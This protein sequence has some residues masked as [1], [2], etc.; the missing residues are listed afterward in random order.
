MTNGRETTSAKR[1]A[2]V[3][4]IND[5]QD[6]NNHLPSCINDVKA[7]EKTLKED[8]AFQDIVRLVDSE[9][10]VANVTV[11]LK[12]LFADASPDDR[13]VFFFSG[14]GS[15]ELRSGV[16][17]Q[18]MVLYDGFLF[19][20]VLS[21]MSQSLPPGI[22]TLVAD[23][24]FSGGLEK[25]LRVAASTECG[26]ANRARV[27]AYTHPTSE[28]CIEYGYAD[29]NATEAKRFGQATFLGGSKVR[30]AS[31]S[32]RAQLN[33]VLL[34]ACLE[35][36]TASASN[37]LTGGK[38]AFT[39]ALLH[40]LKE[41]GRGAA[42]GA[43]TRAVQLTID[44]IG[45]TQTPTLKEPPNP[46]DLRFRTFINFGAAKADET[47]E[48][49]TDL[50]SGPLEVIERVLTGELTM[51]V[52]T[53]IQMLISGAKENTSAK[54]TI[55]PMDSAILTSAI[56]SMIAAAGKELQPDAN[57]SSLL[58]QAFLDE[59]A[60]D[61]RSADQKLFGISNATLMST[62]ASIIRAA[63]KGQQ[64]EKIEKNLLG[65]AI[66]VAPMIAAIVRAVIKSQQSSEV[67]KSHAIRVVHDLIK[68]QPLINQTRA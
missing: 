15:T 53:L 41:L 18:C 59:L 11:A 35:N 43:L 61:Q 54:Q 56:A 52:S 68:D 57:S 2:V 20:D 58:D 40:S 10:A 7:F 31:P 65:H 12:R 19:D 9:A 23:C 22:F 42:L 46:G 5:Y 63:V 39:F 4:G 60:K 49:A 28:K 62:I 3:V 30:A 8:Y 48:T 6:G 44:N 13:L 38:S 29:N 66:R 24:C 21:Q 16:V 25:R 36:E 51:D 27:K 32:S 45:L 37:D 47:S 55:S 26:A 14:H 50:T 64:P 33:G 34:S 1:R 17:E 67:E